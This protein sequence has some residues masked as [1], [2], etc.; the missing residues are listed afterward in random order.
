[1]NDALQQWQ[2]KW[3]KLHILLPEKEEFKNG[4]NEVY[5]HWELSKKDIKIEVVIELDKKNYCG[6]YYGCRTEKANEQSYILSKI[7]IFN[8]K[9]DY[10][11]KYWSKRNPYNKR[12]DIE[13]V[14]LLDDGHT[15]AN[16]YWPFWIRLEEKYSIDEA[17]IAS[18]VI[19]ESLK[20]QGWNFI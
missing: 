11:K 9:E 2:K 5:Y 18:Q 19:I 7:D 20:H 12:N 3:E 8:I 14:F 10:F 13:N 1:M 17:V 4:E 6:I 15:S 16:K